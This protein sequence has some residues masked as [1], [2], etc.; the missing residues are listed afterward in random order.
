MKLIRIKDGDNFIYKNK[1]GKTIDDTETID[2]IKKNRIPPAYTNV[3]IDTNPSSKVFATGYDDKQRKQYIYNKFFSE[4]KQAE[5]FCKMKTVALAMPKLQK[6]LRRNLAQKKI[7]KKKLIAILIKVMAECNFRL[8]NEKYV[9]LYN[10]YGISTILVEHLIV[11]G[12]N[13][14]IRFVGKK[15]VVNNCIVHNKV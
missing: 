9:E 15:G 13:F 6:S 12:N 7:N 5:K 3:E 10:S 2:I 1:R 8:G 11:E 4:K 14:T